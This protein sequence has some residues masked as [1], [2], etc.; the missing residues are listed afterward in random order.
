MIASP[1]IRVL[2]VSASDL[3]GRAFNGYDLT[4]CINLSGSASSEMAVWKKSSSNPRVNEISSVLSSCLNKASLLLCKYLSLDNLLSLGACSLL[5][6]PSVR[7]ANILH[8]QLIHNGIFLSPYLVYLLS[9]MRPTAWTLHDMWPLTGACIQSLDCSK[10]LS[11]CS[12]K[13]PT[14][15]TNGYLKYYTPHLLAL[16]KHYIFKHADVNL[17]VASKWMLDKCRMSSWAKHKN[18]FV[19]PFGVSTDIFSISRRSK[20]RSKFGLGYAEQVLSFRGVD[21]Q[22]DRFKG[23][24]TLVDA[25][26]IL[27]MDRVF[28]CIV[29]QDS[30]SFE[31]LSPRIRL[32]RVGDLRN[33]FDIADALCASDIFVMPSFS[34]SFG[35]MAVEAMSCGVPVIASNAGALPEHVRPP[36]GGILFKVGDSEE[37]AE[38]ISHLLDSQHLRN[39]ISYNG[40]QIVEEEY[41]IEQYV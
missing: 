28:T 37:L 31:F 1:K 9:R 24:R 18:L 20:A 19:I 14:P 11:N 22:R 27:S 6:S 25:L 16:Q 8:L 7:K 26:S 41:T 29:F 12:G 30:S 36:D 15:R 5:I 10:W 3:S 35:M 34:E 21:L 33:P 32:I 17:V 38:S 40:R 23:I 13:C 39:D 2:Q 4:N